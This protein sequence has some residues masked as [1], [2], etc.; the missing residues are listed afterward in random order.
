MVNLQDLPSWWCRVEPQTSVQ[1]CRR[2]GQKCLNQLL[3]RWK[4]PPQQAWQTNACTL[5]CIVHACS[6]QSSRQVSELPGVLPS[7][8]A[9]S[10]VG[11]PWLHRY[12]GAGFTPC[13]YP[14]QEQRAEQSTF[15]AT[16]HRPEG[17]ARCAAPVVRRIFPRPASAPLHTLSPRLTE[18]TWSHTFVRL[19]RRVCPS[20][21][22]QV[23]PHASLPRRSLGGST[24]EGFAAHSL[25]TGHGAVACPLIAFALLSGRARTALT[26]V[27]L[28]L[29]APQQR[30]RRHA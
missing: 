26:G 7:S 22:S 1:H 16:R 9:P 3:G 4:L 5:L 2:A 28:R 21:L 6:P 25:L 11:V 20:C 23:G 17:P 14:V 12:L 18:S 19:Q 8:S 10:T 24:A 13:D 15:P 27:L 29:A 30:R